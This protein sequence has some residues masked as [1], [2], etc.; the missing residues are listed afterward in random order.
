M[1]RVLCCWIGNT[2]L[3]AAAGDASAG[4]G[5]IGQ[6]L[7]KREFDEVVLLSNYPKKQ[8]DPFRNWV[9]G[10]TRAKVAFEQVTLADPTDFAAVY[11]LADGALTRLRERFQKA[12]A[13]LQLTLHLSPG[14]PVM[15]AVWV[16][17]GKTKH[18]AELI[19]TSKERGLQ[20]TSVP[21]DIAAEFVDLIPE[22]LRRPDAALEAR[23]GG[24]LPSAPSFGD[25]VY[26]CAAMADVVG[27]ARKVAMRRVA[28]LIEG[29]SGSGKELLA[30]AIHQEGPRKN[31]P[32]VAV[33]CGALPKDLV[34]S[35]LFGHKKG[36][37]TGAVTD[38]KGYFREAK[39]GTLFLDEVG[40]LP[41]EAQ[42]KLLRALQE[43][44]VVPVGETRAQ[45]IDVRVIAATNRNLAAECRAGQFR[46]DL[47]YRLAIAVL[48][49]PPLRD[50]KGDLGPLVDSLLEKANAIGAQEEPGYKRKALSPGARNLLLNHGWPGN[51]RE[52]ENTLMR[53]T[54]WTEGSTIEERDARAAI[55]SVGASDT[56]AIASRPLGDG[57][58]LDAYLDELSRSYVVR[59]LKEAG[60]NKR[61]AA[62]LLGLNSRQT[63]NNRMKSLG[64]TE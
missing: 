47:F 11:Q 5:P 43:K 36:A 60:G 18:P 48:R 23:S 51:V 64:V 62:K 58:E 41:L 20:T 28:V 52:L 49:L 4:K 26:R 38:A 33:N 22:L 44:Q 54:V 24:A 21:L 17:L 55:M 31:E 14:T 56:G 25:I 9:N 29:E 16:I 19:Q 45:P 30:R 32:F 50:R 53:A 13:P 12:R 34:E 3:R 37:F 42:V 59:A 35:Q 1:L 8:L 57:F 63:L 39:G 7:E 61:L 6:A 2:D 40:E 15:T 10:L 46:Q 27:R